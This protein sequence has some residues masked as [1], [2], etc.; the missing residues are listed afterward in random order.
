MTRLKTPVMKPN[1]TAQR[2]ATSAQINFMPCAITPYRSKQLKPCKWERTL[3]MNAY[4]EG[5]TRDAIP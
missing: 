4:A 1:A 2:A 3:V 5:G